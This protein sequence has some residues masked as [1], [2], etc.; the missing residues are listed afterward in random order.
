MAEHEPAHAD[1]V[2]AVV[3][4][5]DWLTSRLRGAGAALVTDRGD[6]SG[7]GYWS[8]STGS[9]RLDLLEAAFGRPLEV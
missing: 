2:A 8:P 7:T 9:Y 6:A 1:R 3:L 4:P 5:H